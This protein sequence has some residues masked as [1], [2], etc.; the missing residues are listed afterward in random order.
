MTPN[1]ILGIDPG[2]N[3]ALAI[4]D[5]THDH[6]LILVKDM[7]SQPRN[8]DGRKAID[9]HALS[10][11]VGLYAREIDFCVIE[12][13]H[14]MTYKDKVTGQIRGQGAAASFEFGRAM[15]IVQ[16]VVA[17]FMIKTVLV[18]PSAWKM[19]MGLSSNKQDSLDRIAALYPNQ[20]S[21]FFSRK[22]DEGR[23]EAVLL[24]RYASRYVGRLGERILE[25][26]G[27]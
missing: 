4:V 20:T 21:K 8:H 5:P 16:G 18:S 9:L 25:R 6:K 10:L 3:G 26:G 1:L 22:K 15:G 13:V 17:S 12:S 23:A 14:A 24:C 7:P 11:I 19:A 27:N 2:F